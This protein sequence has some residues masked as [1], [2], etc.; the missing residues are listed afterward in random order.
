MFTSTLAILCLVLF[1]YK[2]R[3]LFLIGIP[4]L[5]F[6]VS[7]TGFAYWYTYLNSPDSCSADE[8]PKWMGI[9][10]EV[11]LFLF[12]MGHLFFAT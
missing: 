7:I 4:V 12:N 9:A 2:R 3:E 10:S 5:F 8:C 11:S 1:F 6:L